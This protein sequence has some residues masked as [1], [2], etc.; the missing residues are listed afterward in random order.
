MAFIGTPIALA[1]GFFLAA[2]IGLAGWKLQALTRSGTLGATFIGGLVFGFGGPTWALILIAFFV[3]SSLISRIGSRRKARAAATFEKAGPRDFAQTMANGGIAA[4]MALIVG[5]VG[6]HASLYPYCTLAYLGALAA[7]TADTWATELGMLSRQRPRLITSGQPVQTGISG[8]VTLLGLLGSMGGG[9]FLGISAF[10][11]IQA[12]SLATTGQWFL[13]DSFLLIILP[14]A[15]L[16]GSLT[17]SVLGATL[18]RLY[19]CEQCQ[20]PTEQAIHSCGHS[21]RLLHGVSWMNNDSINFLATCAGAIIAIL[22]A[23][24]FL[25]L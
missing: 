25:S 2:I 13:S 9:L 7:A 12:A 16:I 5:F 15:G 4:L 23:Q 14:I 8:G 10:V 11:F 1:I 19:Y 3:G 24:P 20:T 6:H 18:Q 22:A 21:A 17:D